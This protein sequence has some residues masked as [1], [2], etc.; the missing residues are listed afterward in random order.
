M[1]KKLYKVIFMIIVSIIFIINMSVNNAFAITNDDKNIN[2]KRITVEDGLSQTSVEYLFQD[3]KG[4]MWIG[5]IDGLNRYNGSR[6]EVFRYSKDKPNSISGNYISAIAEDDE[7]NIWV[8]T[9]RGLNRINTHTSEI[10]T[11]LPGV[12]GCNLSNYNITE[13]L[14]DSKGDI[15]I[16]TEDGLNLY[17]EEDDN[18][19]RLYNSG[20]KKNSLSSQFVYSIVEDNYGNYWIGTDN[21][22]NKIENN[23]QKIIKYY[24]DGGDN[25][26]NDN[27]IFKLYADNLDN[28]WIGTYNGGLN[29]LDLKTNKIEK[30]ENDPN[31]DTSIAGN[32][33]RYIL[34]DSRNE[35]WIATNNGLSRL[36]EEENKFI[37]YK[38]KIYDPQSIVSNNVLSLFEDKSGAIWVG[39]YDGISLFNPQNSFKNYKNDPFNTN[40]LSENMMAGI[41]EDDEG[42][43]WVGTVN[44]GLNL[45]DRKSGNITKFKSSDDEDSLSN[46]HIRDIV[47]IQNEIW[48]ATEFGLN[49]YDKLTKKF[50]R[51][52]NEDN[53]NSLL[54]NDVRTLYIDNEGIL[55]IGTRDGLCT[56]D[57][58]DT[59]KSYEDI[60]IKNGITE[61]VFSDIIQDK[62]GVIWIAS[63][64]DGGL[65]RLNKNT[66]E[67]KSYRNNEED[68]YSISFNA[69]KTIAI[70]SKNNIWIGSQFGLNKFDRSTEKFHRY[71]EDS[72]LS[73]NF[74]Y[75][76]LID[77][78]DNP[79]MSTNYGIS[80]FDIKN[81]KFVDYNVTDGLQSN[82]FNGYSYFKSKSG[83]MFF[84]GINGLTYFYPNQLEEKKFSPNVVIDSIYSGEK[85]ILDISN[86]KIGYKNSNIQFNFFMPDYRNVSKIQYAY[87]L[88]G[89][90]ENWIFSDDR[91]YVS[92]TNLESGVY[93]FQ[94]VARNS[95]GDWSKVTTVSFKVGMKPWQTPLAY[96]IYA[97][98]VSLVLYIIWNRVKI[99]DSLVEQRTHEL[100]SKLKENKELYDKL[101]K[102]EKYKNNYFVNLSHELRTPLN[103]IIST[104]QLI[105]K[106]NE[107]DKDIPKEKILYYM[108]T[109][110]RN[111]D[112]LLK[113]INNII[114][115]SKIESG[116]YKLIIEKHD[117]VY[118]VE[119]IVL[120]MKD[121]I[122]AN[123]IELVID[124][125]VEEK[126]IEC[127]G[128]EIEKCIVNLVGNAVKF[129]PR[130]GK[131]EVRI[132][133]LNNKVKISVKDSGIGIEKK[134][135][136]AI[137]D[138]FGQAYNDVSEE[139]GGS[140]LGLTVTKQLVTLHNGRIFVKSEPGH[141]SEFVI[142][143]P[144]KYTM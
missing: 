31:D 79:W 62:D 58:K 22:L 32:F 77:N 85:E 38:S 69:L 103:V 83:E 60:F 112:R 29:K 19:I 78:E 40:S 107:E 68:R 125:D 139:H 113:L 130:G 11:Y 100:N 24:S 48:I 12:N 110:R 4:Y 9:S 144:V 5:T 96:V 53:E 86:I 82:E 13:I 20:D 120:S 37:N 89:L 59:F 36:N 98:I 46:N 128:S 93:K 127:D 33:I 1:R 74:I 34:R 142:I 30:F 8:G 6:F 28:L 137:F 39:T 90:D 97:L 42:L 18:F 109:L 64:L 45:I 81:D 101:I 133:D 121:F 84:G 51:Y 2:F 136:D 116:S 105:T 122:E 114:D 92:Y 117:I 41:Y 135:H 94:V 63:A 7:G 104:Q 99:L 111:S 126:I 123:G 27:F 70:D 14:I 115:T 102:N 72:G 23:S 124:P 108:S 47:G 71:T 118:L 67:I 141:G 131:I 91:N 50:T 15:Y 140:G 55:W 143:L 134:Y 57:R 80:K 129:T 61:N 16:A 44:E 95:S 119:E 52:Y 54:Y 25:S 73:N 106:L 66:N 65:I 17:N 88:D 43:L 132:V 35:L 3:S 76:I 56:F 138:R 21:G 49:K 26:I 75:G 87:K 10:T